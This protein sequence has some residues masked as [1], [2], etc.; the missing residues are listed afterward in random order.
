MNLFNETIFYSFLSDFSIIILKYSIVMK[1]YFEITQKVSIFDDKTKII[2]SLINN[3]Y[4]KI[5]AMFEEID[6]FA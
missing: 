5:S 2:I 6:A 1:I 4:P 3:L